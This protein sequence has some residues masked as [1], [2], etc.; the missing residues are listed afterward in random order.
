MKRNIFILCSFIVFAVFTSY[1]QSLTEQA[2]AA[3]NKDDFNQ[4]LELY[5]EA[6]QQEGTSSE[7][8]YNIG[9]TYYKLDKKGKAILY[10]ERALLLDPNNSNARDNLDYVRSK[11]S[12]TTDIGA[13]YWKDSIDNMVCSQTATAWGVL[14]VVS[15]LAFIVLLFVCIFGDAVILRKIGFFGGGIMLIVTILANICAFH[16]KSKVEAH[17]QA[18]VVIPSATLSTSPRQPKDKTEEAFMLNE[19]TKV[20]VIDSV[21]NVVSGSNEKWYDVRANETSR[22]WIAASAIEII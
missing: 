11:S 8:F 21:T 6:S 9:N 1:A 22:A 16:V 12:M 4:A 14:A 2:A 13:T 7:L 19:G 5:L 15:F 3:Y 20:T 17:D 18:V 10:Y